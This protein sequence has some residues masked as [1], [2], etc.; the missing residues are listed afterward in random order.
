MLECVAAERQIELVRSLY[1]A[2]ARGDTDAISRLLDPGFVGMATAG[3][4]D[5]IGGTHH[6]PQGMWEGCWL[7]LGRAADVRVEPIEWIPCADGRLLVSG[8]YV[9][10]A[11][12]TEAELDAAFMHLISFE[13]GERLRITRLVQLTDSARWSAVLAGARA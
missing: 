1:A 3:L 4:G 5:G 2:L 11:R 7:Q 6:G 13:N 9:G 12:R 10:S 8:R